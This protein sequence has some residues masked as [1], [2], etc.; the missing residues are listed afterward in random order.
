[1]ISFTK[2]GFMALAPYQITKRNDAV[3]GS[4]DS[5]IPNFERLLEYSS[6]DGHKKANNIGIEPFYH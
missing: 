6:N 2:Y 1:M 5:M 4:A 3:H